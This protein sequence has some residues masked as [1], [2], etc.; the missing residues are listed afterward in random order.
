MPFVS[1]EF[2]S[3]VGLLC[4]RGLVGMELLMV[5][6]GSQLRFSYAESRSCVL[7]TLDQVLHSRFSHNCLSVL[8]LITLVVLLQGGGTSSHPRLKNK[9]MGK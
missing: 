9:T 7:K 5:S 2:C 8:L 4:K 6:E 3:D 1:Q